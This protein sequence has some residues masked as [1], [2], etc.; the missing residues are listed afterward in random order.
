MLTGKRLARELWIV[1]LLKLVVLTGLWW[2]F[3]RDARVT[4]DP[5]AVA[6]NFTAAPGNP[7]QETPAHDQ[8]STR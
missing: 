1:V 5:A 8:R 6:R 7:S 4:V 3:V 2:A